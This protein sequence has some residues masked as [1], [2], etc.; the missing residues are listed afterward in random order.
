MLGINIG[1]H[2]SGLAWLTIR[3]PLDYSF[4]VYQSERFLKIK[5]AGGFPFSAFKKF[6]LDHPETFAQITTADVAVNCFERTPEEAERIYGNDPQYQKYLSLLNLEKFSTLHQKNLTRPG[7][8]LCHAY[9]VWG[10]SPFERA[11][12]IVFDGCGSRRDSFEDYLMENDLGERKAGDQFETLS[13]YLLEDG[14][15][16]PVYK[17]WTHYDKVDSINHFLGDSLGNDFSVAAQVIF[18]KFREAGKVMGLSAFGKPLNLP[19]EELKASLLASLPKVY[20]G[21][22]E[23]D[24]QPMESFRRSADIAATIQKHFEETFLGLL[25]NLKKKFPEFENLILA[26]GCALNCLTNSRIVQKQLFRNVFIPPFPNDEGIAMGAALFHAHRKGKISFRPLSNDQLTA[27][28]GRQRSQIS[29]D[30]LSDWFPKFDILSFEKAAEVLA[31]GHV[32]AHFNSRSE[33]GPRAL[34]NRSI[35]VRPDRVDVKKYLND[36]IKFRERFRP[37]GATV[38]EED[39]STY[40]EVEEGFYAPFMTFAPPVRKDKS[41]YL[42]GVTHQDGTCRIQTISRKQNPEFYNLIESFK[43]LTG[44]SVLLNTSLNIMGQP[45]L[46]DIEDLKVFAETSRIDYFIVDGILMKRK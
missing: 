20:Q 39:A 6:R 38:L 19:V 21:K 2:D 25:Q 5:Q 46:E 4:E 30:Q 7:H 24:Q 15:L 36:N 17:E 10:F 28:L 45:I 32:V 22:E 13:V 42:A 29:V 35:L 26:G 11:M 37:Y 34:G 40:F 33:V 44:E 12:V 8:H 43:K 18:G 27:Y 31:Q 16:N 9:S 23:F 3:S 14:I 1:A 41:T